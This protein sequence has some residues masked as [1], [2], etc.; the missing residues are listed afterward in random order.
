MLLKI[1]L[2]KNVVGMQVVI[3]LK[4]PSVISV[5]Y[6]SAITHAQA[7]MWNWM[8]PCKHRHTVPQNV[9]PSMIHTLTDLLHL[10]LK[11][12]R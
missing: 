3:Y 10:L 1:L 12:L 4:S 9:F 7:P 2:P 5:T 11:V 8:V 6:C